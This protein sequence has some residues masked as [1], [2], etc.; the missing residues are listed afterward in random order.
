MRILVDGHELA[1]AARHVGDVLDKTDARKQGVTLTMDGDTLT[2]RAT[3]PT[4]WSSS[5]IGAEAID[6][7]VEPITVNGLWLMGLAGALPDGET[8]VETDGHALTL[9]GNG[10]RLRMQTMGDSSSDWP[11]LPEELSP[12]DEGVLRLVAARTVNMASRDQSRP[13][14]RGV[15]LEGDGTTLSMSATDRYR[16]AKASV[17]PVAWTG[18]VIVNAEWVKRHA[19]DARGL[20]ANGRMLVIAGDHEL[21]AS[22]LIDGE[23]PILDR[24][25]PDKDHADLT[26]TFDRRSLLDAAK[27]LRAVDMSGASATPL[28]LDANEEGLK[29]SLTGTETMGV[30]RLDARVEGGLSDRLRVNAQY[31]IDALNA[32]DG[33]HATLWAQ[34]GFRPLLV[35]GEDSGSDS[36]QM[37]TPIRD[38]I[39]D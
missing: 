15:L 26:V 12:F 7:P 38:M 39:A 2:L 5:M 33:E 10:I 1:Q 29:V 25:W 20:S 11:D 18:R 28:L 19:M 3:G 17:T 6:P 16:A 9:T 14:L 35:E 32:V 30:Q 24:I 8:D 34:N 22:M 37:I 13:V 21:D 23:Y 31:L 27:R 36:M 4:E